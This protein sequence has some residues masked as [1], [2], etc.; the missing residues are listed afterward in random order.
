MRVFER[1]RNITYD[2]HI[3]GCFRRA[4]YRTHILTTKNLCHRLFL[5]LSFLTLLPTATAVFVCVVVV[6]LIVAAAVKAGS[7]R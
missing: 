6:V 3:A 1:T 2:R 7:C 5:F 4:T